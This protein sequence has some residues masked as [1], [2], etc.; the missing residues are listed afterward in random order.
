MITNFERIFNFA[1]TDF[2]RNKGSNIA[3]I[4]V[5]VVTILLATGLLMFQGMANHIISEIQNKIDITAY[6][7][8]GTGEENI[9]SVKD[10]ITNLSP[11]I[12][13]VTYVSEAQALQEFNEKHQ[14]NE[15]LARA[16]EEVGGNPFLSSLNIVTTGK[17]SQ[18][19]N[20]SNILQSD[21]Y[22]GLIEKV[23]FSQKRDIIEKVFS[24]TS[25]VNKFGIGLGIFMMVIAILVVLNTIKLTVDNSKDE[26]STMKIVGASD[27]FVRGPFVIQGAI[28]GVIAF[29]ISFAISLIAVYLFSSKI[30][31]IMPG[32]FAFKYFISNIII[33]ILVQLGFG[34]FLGI[35]S[36]FIVIRRYL[37][38]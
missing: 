1:V 12:K 23:D 11:D 25:N 30:S 21:K 14:G 10:E 32:F 24:I 36:S 6:F 5:L 18:Y 16:I 13:S 38:V 15:S 28:Y 27:W 34:I 20:I 26:I 37:K 8:E 22:K 29:A 4:F 33:F 19:E 2:R 7:K 31:L 17:T 3:A 35:I 9:L